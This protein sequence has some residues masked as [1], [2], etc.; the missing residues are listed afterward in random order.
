MGF[1]VEPSAMYTNMETLSLVDTLQQCW[2]KLF[3]LP[4]LEVEPARA[5]T[6]SLKRNCRLE[7]KTTFVQGSK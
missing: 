7:V 3:S 2:Q 5:R 4:W 1:Q 6:Q